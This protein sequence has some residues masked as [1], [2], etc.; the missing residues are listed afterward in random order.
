MRA[1]SLPSAELNASGRITVAWLDCRFRV[2]CGKQVI[3]NDV[4]LSSSSDGRRWTRVRRVPTG[5]DLDG[6]PHLVS[7]LAVD[8]S[9]S[10]RK[11]RLAVAFYVVTPRGCKQEDCLLAPFFVSSSDAGQGWTQ[12]QPLAPAEPLDAYPDTSS[13]RFVGDYISTSFVATG[14]AVP[15]F[16][17][18]SRGFDGRYHQG[19]FAAAVQMRSSTPVL[20][21]DPPRVRPR[22]PRSGSRIAVSVSI[23]G[24]TAGLRVGCR[25][26]QAGDRMLLV[27]RSVTNRT[28]SCIWRL[29]PGRAG[30]L[31]SG[32][33]VL[34]T[35]EVDVTRRFRLRAR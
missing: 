5:P 24:L 17:A 33:I 28:V 31:I 2:G 15:V 20:R 12:P 27:A 6:L 4:V 10:G 29:R 8:S 16:A 21:V 25:T 26:D 7:G 11:T 32:T 23:A 34:T 18:A 1:P 22:R 14:H 19:I 13:G 35:P 3:A 30:Q 9:T